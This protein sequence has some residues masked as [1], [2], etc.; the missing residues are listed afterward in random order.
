M[1]HVE[2][3]GR[4][5]E[6]WRSA[7]EA[8]ADPDPEIDRLVN[9]KVVSIRFAVLTQLLGKLADPSRDVLAVQRGPAEGADV[10]GR[11]DARSLCTQVVVP[12]NQK[13]RNVLGGS[14][15]PY[16]NNPLRR[17]RLDDQ[18]EALR[19]RAE[20]DAL[21]SLLQH[22]TARDDVVAL[23][24]AVLRCLRSVA[25]RLNQQVVHY[26]VPPRVSLNQVLCLLET[27][28]SSPSAGLRSMAAATALLK[29]VGRSLG[30]FSVTSQGLNES[31]AASNVSGDIVCSGDDGHP[32]LV[33]EVKERDLTLKEFES[34][35]TK[36]RSHG[37]STVTFLVPGLRVQDEKAIRDRTAA[38]W[39]QGTDVH[40]TSLPRF[41]EAVLLFVEERWRHE[42][43]SEIGAELN[44]RNASHEHRRA[45]ADLLER[46]HHQVL[47]M[48]S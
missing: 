48:N 27:Y 30:L 37:V 18:M 47:A 22:A 15:D 3:A 23:E 25:R 38:V 11:W 14:A 1:N 43:L 32:V 12:W 39:A 41:A 2:L 7:T 31:D 13:N 44:R 24:A 19:Y 4:L 9:S 17:P 21:V 8:P 5:R 28:L 42:L 20:W 6:S 40:A 29:I 26:A 33:V 10:T 36:A 34:T 46:L 35:V 45:F 16:V